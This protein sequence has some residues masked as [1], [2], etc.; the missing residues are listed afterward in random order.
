MVRMVLI[1]VMVRSKLT[2]VKMEMVTVVVGY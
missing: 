1:E 2:V